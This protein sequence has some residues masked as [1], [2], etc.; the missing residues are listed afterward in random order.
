MKPMRSMLVGLV[1][2]VTSI[3]VLTGTA[4]AATAASTTAPLTV[5]AAAPAAA[6]VTWHKLKLMDGWQPGPSFDETGPPAWGIKNGIVYLA[7]ELT[8]PSGGG[9]EF[10]KLPPAARPS[11]TL[12]IVVHVP[13][14]PSV[15]GGTYAWLTIFR[16]GEMF[17]NSATQSLAQS[18]TELGA[19][20]FLAAST[21]T[22]RLR[23][24]HGWQPA[25]RSYGTGSPSYT[26]RGG[27]VYLAGSLQG[28]SATANV[29][30]VLPRGA[31]PEHTL[32]ITVYT[33]GGT[34]GLLEIFPDGQM[35]VSAAGNQAQTFTSLA[36]VSFPAAAMKLHGLTLLFG[37][38]SSEQTVL[39]TGHPAYAVSKGIVYLSGGLHQPSPS[40]DNF[41]RL[42]KA[43]RPRHLVYV[44]IYTEDAVIGILQIYPNGRLWLISFPNANAQEFSS[45]AAISYPVNS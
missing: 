6:G 16:D 31:R 39:N 36:G 35:T 44:K 9:Y 12:Y 19:V 41:A 22:R 42:P 2:T 38:Q 30:A 17:D 7:G 3:A 13:G 32:L 5:P 4:G 1:G 40:S 33:F 10:A 37:W 20:S 26:V 15:S 21:T 25:A 45:L 43:A 18:A 29:F 27:V 14:D 8:Q 24:V 34:T 28:Q 11:R 23:P